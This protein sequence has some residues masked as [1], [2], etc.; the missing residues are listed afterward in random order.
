MAG[1]EA[2]APRSG[3]GRD[4]RIR[5]QSPDPAKRDFWEEWRR[6]RLGA[7]APC[8]ERNYGN[9]LPRSVKEASFFCD[10]MHFEKGKRG[11]D[12]LKAQEEESV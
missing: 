12:F 9:F 6:W 7:T 1:L 3:L 5:I 8:P 11:V 4:G 10:G 2:E